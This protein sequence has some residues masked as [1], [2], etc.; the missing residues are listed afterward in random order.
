MV[1]FILF[2][3][4]FQIIISKKKK[5]SDGQKQIGKHSTIVVEFHGPTGFLVYCMVV[6]NTVN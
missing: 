4:F 5:C 2:Y 1:I 6:M 3:F